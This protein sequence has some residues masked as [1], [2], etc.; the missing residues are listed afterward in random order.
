MYARTNSPEQMLRINPL[1]RGASVLSLIVALSLAGMA[2]AQTDVNM[3]T[4]PTVTAAQPSGATT[5][6]PVMIGTPKPP[7][8][9]TGAYVAEAVGDDIFIRSGAGTNYYKC[10][11]LYKGDRIQVVSTQQGWAC[12]V[13]PPG[14][15]S[16]I[17]MQYVSI[18][19]DNPTMGIVTGDNVRIYA[20]SDFVEPMHSTS[21][22]VKLFRGDNVKL[23]GEEKD[24]YYKIA[25][26][27]GAY[28]WV[29]TQFVQVVQAGPGRASPGTGGPGVQV[30]GQQPQVKPGTESELLDAYYAMVTQLK[31]ERAK[32]MAE[33]NYDALKGKLQEIAK[34]QE[35]GKAAKYAEFSLKQIERF[36]LARTVGKE[37]ELQS[38]ERAKVNSK[39]DEA[40]QA[41]LAQ[42]ENLGKFAVVGKLAGSSLYPSTDQTKRYRILDELGK[43]ICYIAPAAGATGQDLTPLMGKKVGLVG[44]IQPHEPTARAFITYTQVVPLE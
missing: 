22:Q 39:I 32:P 42:I 29:S 33:Q 21:E 41:R 36:E 5:Q 31:A 14:C 9:P 25:P 44:D 27:Q 6:P 4:Q 13:P 28:L 1:C 37:I 30:A 7:E 3:A 20:G 12:I 40:R 19:L 43:T 23:L 38:Q 2:A 11:K 17:P 35:A 15:F 34:N 10:G 16:W 26:P 24:D 18:N 8:T